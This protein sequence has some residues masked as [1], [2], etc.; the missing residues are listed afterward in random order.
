M[1]KSKDKRIALITFADPLMYPPILN[2]HSILTENGYNVDIL[3]IKN[4]NFNFKDNYN[5]FNLVYIDV[6]K[7]GFRFLYS[8]IK[9]IIHIY[10]LASRKNYDWI[11]CYNHKAVLAVYFISKINNIK[12]L[13][14]NHDLSIIKKFGFNKFL[15]WIESWAV[16]NAN[17]ISFPQKKRAEIFSKKNNIEKEICIVYNSPLLNWNIK[18]NISESINSIITNKKVILYQGEL[19]YTRGLANILKSIPHLSEDIILILVGKSEIEPAFNNKFKELIDHL[20]I[21]NRVFI[22]ESLSYFDLS[23]ITNLCDI[24]IGVL[25]TTQDDSNINIRHLFGASNKIFEYMACGLPIIVPYND[26]YYKEIELQKLGLTVDPLSE[27]SIAKAINKILDKSNY[28]IYSNNV[29][30]KFLNEYNYNKQ[31]QKI[32][33]LL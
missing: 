30:D 13:Y 20:N 21:S 19:S 17:I 28:N 1:K 33:K 5:E 4:N 9:F 2:T 18:K 32:L 11:F 31:F 15:K 16:K 14:H 22:F 8:Y 29:S 3:G 12:W 10:K 6:I 25:S 27:N 23:S 7:T 26:E 24:G